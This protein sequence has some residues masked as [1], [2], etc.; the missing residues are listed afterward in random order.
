[1]GWITPYYYDR[2]MDDRTMDDQTMAGNGFIQFGYK[3]CKLAGTVQSTQCSAPVSWSAL[4]TVPGAE[5]IKG[6]NY[7]LALQELAALFSSP[8]S[9]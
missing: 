6:G 7:H 4:D 5:P 8:V 1:M 2:T 3:K 9:T